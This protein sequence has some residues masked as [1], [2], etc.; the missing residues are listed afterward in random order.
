MMK[1]RVEAVTK[2]RLVLAAE[3]MRLVGGARPPTT[4]FIYSCVVSCTYTAGGD[5]TTST[6]F[7]PR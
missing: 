5:C 3:T 7:D 1:K 4:S 6:T 2:R